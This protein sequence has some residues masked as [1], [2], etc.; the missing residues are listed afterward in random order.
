[1]S[2]DLLHQSGSPAD[3]LLT[4]PTMGR[5]EEGAQASGSL[6]LQN[7][8]TQDRLQLRP[9]RDQP[10]GRCGFQSSP[11]VRAK[12]HLPPLEGHVIEGEPTNLRPAPA[13][14]KEGG[15]N[16]VDVMAEAVRRDCSAAAWGE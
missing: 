15:D 8:R 1:M 14:Q 2:I 5:E 10:E 3:H 4:V 9:E 11:G 7:V 6:L 13:R 16:R 12:R